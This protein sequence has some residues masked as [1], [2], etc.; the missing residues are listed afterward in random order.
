MDGRRGEES[1]YINPLSLGDSDSLHSVRS[2]GTK[3][4]GGKVLCCSA[5]VCLKPKILHIP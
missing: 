1:G 2:L 4:V 5:W 3:I